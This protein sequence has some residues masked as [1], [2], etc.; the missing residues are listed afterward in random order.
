[1]FAGTYRPV[2]GAIGALFGT[3]AFTQDYPIRTLPINPG[4]RPTPVFPMTLKETFGKLADKSPGR[5]VIP[6]HSWAAASVAE[7]N[8]KARE[9]HAECRGLISFPIRNQQRDGRPHRYAAAFVVGRAVCARKRDRFR[10]H[11]H[12]P[13]ADRPSIRA[14]AS[15][16]VRSKRNIRPYR[17]LVQ[18][19][20]CRN[21]E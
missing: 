12:K 6:S 15:Q 16:M 2:E 14:V 5:R 13:L 19:A 11:P 3:C 17:M 9:Q 4:C 8:K 1:M 7:A 21:G 20:R 10:L 18:A